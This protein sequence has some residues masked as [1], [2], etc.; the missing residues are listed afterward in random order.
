MD[1]TVTSA[2]QAI[3]VV[4]DMMIMAALGGVSGSGRPDL[5]RSWPR[6]LALIID[7]LRSQAAVSPLEP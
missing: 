3:R 4:R 1:N 2:A 6:L 7:G 5:A